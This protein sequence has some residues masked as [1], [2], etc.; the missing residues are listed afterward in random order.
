MVAIWGLCH[1]R[2][3]SA[4][5]R[6][7]WLSFCALSC[8]SGLLHTLVLL[9]VLWPNMRMHSAAGVRATP[10]GHIFCRLLQPCQFLLLDV[11][12]CVK[13]RLV[14]T[15]AMLQRA[16]LWSAIIGGTACGCCSACSRRAD[17]PHFSF[18]FMLGLHLWDCSLHLLPPLQSL[19]LRRNKDKHADRAWCP[20][21]CAPYGRF[22][23]AR[24]RSLR[25][26][27]SLIASA[28][29]A[30]ARLWC[31]PRP[32]PVLPMKDSLSTW[33][34]RGACVHGGPG[35]GYNR[36][37]VRRCVVLR[38]CDRGCAGRD[39]FAAHLYWLRLAWSW[40][41]FSMIEWVYIQALSTAVIKSG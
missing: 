39:D 2:A 31:D 40:L 26:Q 32:F 4:V 10:C 36:L 21:Q 1:A 6:T 20:C 34:V 28:P 8:S 13:G 9:A 14:L 27:P 41:H 29:A 23:N 24:W 35:D 15:T 30:P 38:S 12:G 5:P 11:V 33:Y 3:S 17:H 25:P 18:S 37:L 22:C 19:A 7:F 16:V